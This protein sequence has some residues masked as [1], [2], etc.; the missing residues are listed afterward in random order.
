[1]IDTVQKRLSRG[2]F[3]KTS[4]TNEKNDDQTRPKIKYRLG[5]V[6]QKSHFMQEQVSKKGKSCPSN[7]RSFGNFNSK[8]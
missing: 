6:P 4:I 8:L 7:Y 1:M 3:N 5:H 2:N